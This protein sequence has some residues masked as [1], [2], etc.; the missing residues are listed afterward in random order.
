MTCRRETR[1][2]AEV[3]KGRSWSANSNS[4]EKQKAEASF[5]HGRAVSAALPVK[6]TG[7]ANHQ[8]NFD[9]AKSFRRTAAGYQN[10]G[11]YPYTSHLRSAFQT[12]LREQ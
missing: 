3:M 7:D 9:L 6:Q 2:S 4:D 8:A 1:T 5:D 10:S 12:P 11:S